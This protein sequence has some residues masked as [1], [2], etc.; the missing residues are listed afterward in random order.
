VKTGEVTSTTVTLTGLI[1]YRDYRFQ[2]AFRNQ[3]GQG[4]YATPVSVV[5]EEDG[6]LFGRYIYDSKKSNYPCI[7]EMK[8]EYLFC[9][10]VYRVS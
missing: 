9:I 4:P 5:T 3:A 8:D 7:P 1:P 2:V 6:K 10:F